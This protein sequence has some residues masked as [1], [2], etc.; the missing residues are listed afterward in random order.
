M[1]TQKH[2][3]ET[4]MLTE[5]NFRGRKGTRGKYYQAYQKGHTVRIHQDDGGVIAQ[6]HT[7]VAVG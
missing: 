7:L 4:E 3:Q 5:Y 6:F 2:E 1:R